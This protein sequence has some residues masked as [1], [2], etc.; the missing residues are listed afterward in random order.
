VVVAAAATSVLSLCE[1]AAL[2]DSGAG[3]STTDS[4]GVLSGSIVQAPVHLPANVCGNTVNVIGLLN[5][6]FGNTCDNELSPVAE[7][8]PDVPAQTGSS[9][10]GSRQTPP[11]TGV[12]ASPP[13]ART[14]APRQPAPA[15]QLPHEAASPGNARG[16]FTQQS[17]AVPASFES[18]PA[19]A[20]T[21][22]EA[23]VAGAGLSAALIAGGVVLLRRGRAVRPQ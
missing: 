18:R 21:G 22:S 16:S 5:P 17:G 10:T 1:I 20:E 6:A 4:P 23:M 13:V 9:D 3:G 19:L 12:V 7:V 2:A 11:P 14:P 15:E 8:R